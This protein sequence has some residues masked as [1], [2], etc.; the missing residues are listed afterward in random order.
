MVGQNLED[1]STIMLHD[2]P[3]ATA[4]LT[5][6][7]PALAIPVPE[8]SALRSLIAAPKNAPEFFTAG[9]QLELLSNCTTERVSQSCDVTRS[10]TH[11]C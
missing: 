9:L 10:H 1:Q 8:G 2:L 3:T 4:C 7:I 11:I 6:G 5:W